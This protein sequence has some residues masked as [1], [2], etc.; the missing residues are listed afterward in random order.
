MKRGRVSLLRSRATPSRAWTPSWTSLMYI[1][2]INA[3]HAGASAC[4]IR[5]GEL[6]AAVEE[7]RFRRSKYW[8]GFP[9]LAINYC[10]SE[11]GISPYDLD[12]VG[13]SRDPSA[14]LHKKVLFALRRRPD[15]GF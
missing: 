5:D 6:V 15:L 7:E 9:S 3:Y 10:L 1:L 12:H 14:N 13:I 2:G 8:A 11:A 4:L